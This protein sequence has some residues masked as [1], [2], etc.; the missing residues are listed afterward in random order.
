MDNRLNIT[1]EQL[2]EAEKSMIEKLKIYR[3]TALDDNKSK[4][5]LKETANDVI[6]TM[7]NYIQLQRESR[8][9]LIILGQLLSDYIA[10]KEPK[11]P[12]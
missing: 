7:G 6:R 4:L 3:A 1:Q 12:N 5:D 8:N 10:G 11:K 2:K 9:E